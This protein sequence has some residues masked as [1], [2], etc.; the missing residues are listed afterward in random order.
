VALQA[1]ATADDTKTG[2][3]AK[4]SAHLHQDLARQQQRQGV[5]L[6]TCVLTCLNIPAEACCSEEQLLHDE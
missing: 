5:W 1:A 3:E 4:A 6:N 2:M